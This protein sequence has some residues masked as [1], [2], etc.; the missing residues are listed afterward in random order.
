M[1]VRKKRHTRRHG[2]LL[3]FVLVWNDWEFGKVKQYDARCLASIR[4]KDI[5]DLSKLKSFW[6]KIIIFMRQNFSRDEQETFFRQINK[7]VPRLFPRR[8]YG[9]DHGIHFSFHENRIHY[10]RRVKH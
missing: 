2:T 6:N 7:H 8:L 9:T 4:E 5:H 3:Q 1:F 10:V